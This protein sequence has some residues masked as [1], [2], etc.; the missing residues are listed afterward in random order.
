MNFRLRGFHRQLKTVSL[1]LIFCRRTY[2]LKFINITGGINGGGDPAQPVNL[3]RTQHCMH[4]HTEECM[5]VSVYRGI[6]LLALPLQTGC[7]L[8]PL[9]CVALQLHHTNSANQ[10][11]EGL[12]YLISCHGNLNKQGPLCGETAVAVFGRSSGKKNSFSN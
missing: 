3:N 11:R 12:R 10:T 5:Y 9:L 4:K 2:R 8:P 7:E 1:A 6:C